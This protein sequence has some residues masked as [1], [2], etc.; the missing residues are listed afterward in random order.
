MVRLLLSCKATLSDDVASLT[1]ER[2]ELRHRRRRSPL[3]DAHGTQA[4]EQVHPSIFDPDT[5]ISKG[6][7]TVAKLRAPET[8]R[9]YY[10]IHGDPNA[11]RKIV[12]SASLPAEMRNRC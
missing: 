8:H 2:G 10:E 1:G 4:E 3:A 6:L 11:T 5:L 9:L 7:C 12:F